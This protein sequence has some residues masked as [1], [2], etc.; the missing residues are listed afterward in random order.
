MSGY[1]AVEI[2][3]F[4]CALMSRAVAL[5]AGRMSD[6]FA[7]LWIAHIKLMTFSTFMHI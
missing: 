6:I 2:F 7:L 4:F 3:D 1:D 5:A